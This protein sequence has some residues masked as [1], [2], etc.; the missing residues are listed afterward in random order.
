MCPKWSQFKHTLRVGPDCHLR[1]GNM[2]VASDLTLFEINV[3]IYGTVLM[4]NLLGLSVLL[5]LIYFR[6]LSWSFSVEVLMVLVVTAIVGCLASLS[7]VFPVWTSLFVYLLYPLSLVLV[8]TFGDF[9][10]SS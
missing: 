7:T 10:W 3:Q 9:E 1:Y 8:N 5:S 4:N 2:I 6:G